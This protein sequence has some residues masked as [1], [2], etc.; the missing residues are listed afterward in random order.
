MSHGEYTRSSIS[1]SDDLELASLNPDHS[2]RTGLDASPIYPSSP[3]THSPI[4]TPALD[5]EGNSAFADPTEEGHDAGN[6]A[7]IVEK[8]KALLRDL[9]VALDA[10]VYIEL[11]VLYYLEYVSCLNH[12]LC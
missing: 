4:P 10:V 6:N 12:V 9:L 8:R 3:R 11:A 5:V 7:V 1:S 2:D